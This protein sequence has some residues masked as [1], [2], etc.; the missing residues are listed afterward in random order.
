MISD[1]LLGL[2]LFLAVPQFLLGCIQ[3]ALGLHSFMP[4][5]KASFVR[6][7]IKSLSI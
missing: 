7:E 4:V 5:C 6:L 2:S 3:F 1:K